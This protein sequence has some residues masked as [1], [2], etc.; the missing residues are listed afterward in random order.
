MTGITWLSLKILVLLWV[1]N[2]VPAFLAFLLEDKWRTP[3]D[4]GFV[5]RD[6]RPL[7]GHHKTFRGL[8]AALISGVA[9]GSVLGFPWTDGFWV[10]SLS[11]AGDLLTS[12]L[13][14][15]LGEPAGGVMP[16]LDQ[17]L[18]GL[19]P[20]AYLASTSPLRVSQ[21]LMLLLLFCAGALVG[22][23][24]FKLVLLRSPYEGYPRKVSPRVR[25][26]ELRACRI[27]SDP[28]HHLV[29]FENAIYYHLLMK[30]VFRLS[31]IYARGV[32]NA[33]RLRL[34]RLDLRFADL[35]ADF[36]G[37]TI[38]FLSDLHL[39][40]LDG[41]TERLVEVVASIQV[42]CC[43][44]GG[45]F[46]MEM[47]GPFEEAL[48]RTETLL[49]AI[50]SR[51][52]L[53]GILGNHDCVE[54]IPRLEGL[55]VRVL[56]NESAPIRRG[57]SQ[58]WLVGVDDPHYFRCHDVQHAFK[59]V[60]KAAFPIFL[61]HSPEVYEQAER[62]GARLYL[63]GHTH[64]GQIQIPRIGPLFTHSRSPKHVCSGVW[65]HGGMIGYTTS[66][67]GVSGVPVRYHTIG[68]AILLTLRT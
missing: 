14:R 67:A 31:G 44:L 16:G 26:R 61:S 21:S 55:G 39:D 40:G 2:F 66:G 32:S 30:T 1:I 25:L 37:Y 58:I 65:R 12:F 45:D 59:D 52:G 41:L 38:L 62:Q 68:E 60:P 48:S 18:E 17:V 24:F 11:M 36:E 27:A 22:S 23:W 51:D 8:I 29:N 6:G 56:L 4:R 10:A 63:C 47:S 28:L 35:P 64:W 15:R 42:D 57:N 46:R 9:A 7:L 5:F 50:R 3:I 33:L 43:I 53:F 19:F 20:L 54:M 49:G 13:K 34:G